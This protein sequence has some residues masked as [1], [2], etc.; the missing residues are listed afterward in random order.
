MTK[1]FE[2]LGIPMVRIPAVNGYQLKL[3]HPDYNEGLFHRIHG[4]TTNP[5]EIGCYLSHIEAFKVFLA[6]SDT[7]ALIC[8]DDIV[9]K[10]DLQTVLKEVMAYSSRWNVV[11]LSGLSDGNPLKVA[12]LSGGY[13]LCLCLGRLKGTGA[14]LIDRAAAKA[15]VTGLV[16]MRLPY[17]HAVDRE[18]FYGMKAAYVQP[19]PLLQDER[20][21]KSTIQKTSGKRL[22]KWRRM[23]TV[24]PYQI[25]NETCRIIS[26]GLSW[27]GWK[28]GGKAG[29][30]P[31]SQPASEH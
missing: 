31:Q 16:P 25:Y 15:F 13:N 12:P 24:Y 27:M 3:P 21:F 8:E 26:R 6:T 5:G 30:P 17:D 11:R 18:W 7:H 20:I 1:S 22:P 19:F 29:K 2:P 14:Y 10:P 23:L 9:L 28:L 4:R